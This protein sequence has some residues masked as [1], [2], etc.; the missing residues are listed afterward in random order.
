M[1]IVQCV[2]KVLLKKFRVSG[3]FSWVSDLIDYE[4]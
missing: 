3:F 1:W 4:N 2:N